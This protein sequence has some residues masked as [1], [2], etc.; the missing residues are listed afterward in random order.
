MQSWPGERQRREVPGGEASTSP[1]QGAGEQD[2][3]VDRAHLRVDRDRHGTGR[4]RGDQREPAAAGAGEADGL[5]RGSVTS[6]WPRSSPVPSRRRTRRGAGRPATARPP[7]GPT[8]SAVPGWAGCALTTTGHPAARRRRCR[9][10]RWRRRAG[11]CSRRTQPPGRAATIAAG[12]RRGAAER[13]RAGPGRSARRGGRRG[14]DLREQAQLAG[15][16]AELA[17]EAGRGEAGLPTAASTIASG[18]R[19]RRRRLEEVA[20]LRAGSWRGRREGLGRGGGG[21]R[22]VGLLGLGA[23]DDR[24]GRLGRRVLRVRVGDRVAASAAASSSAQVRQ[25]RGGPAGGATD[26][27]MP[28]LTMDT[29]YPGVGPGCRGRA[30]RTGESR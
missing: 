15:G 3:R 27:V 14:D 7:R 19:S 4:G 28:P 5:D 6:A 1:G 20:A 24:A 26:H 13:G 10:R 2:D 17:R 12:C 29:P 30:A 11:S 9:R 16:A 25:R 23:G 22:A 8:S 18:R 21:G